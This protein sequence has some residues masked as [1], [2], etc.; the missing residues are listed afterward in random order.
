MLKIM[1]DMQH[2]LTSYLSVVAMINFVVG[3]TAGVVA[4]LVGLPNVLAWA[5]LGFILNFVPYIGALLMQVVLLAVGLVTFPTLTQ[6]LSRAIAL[7]GLHHASKGIL[8]HRP[9]WDGG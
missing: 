3:I 7:S 9:S 4:Y 6:A 2:N 5:V 8:S 1:N